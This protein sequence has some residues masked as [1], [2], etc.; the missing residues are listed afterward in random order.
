MFLGL[1]VGTGALRATPDLGPVERWLE[2]QQRVETIAASFV[3]ER[4]LKTVTKPLRTAGRMWWR[5]ASG[6]LRWQLGEPP[7]LL[8]VRPGRGEDLLV[9]KPAEK[10]GERW[11]VTGSPEGLGALA[12]LDA[13]MAGS[14]VELQTQFEITEV[15]PEATR[16]VIATKVRDR[17]LSLGV[18]R[19]EFVLDPQTSAL[20]ETNVFLR[21]GSS[22]SNQFVEVQLDAPIPPDTFTPALDGYRIS[23]KA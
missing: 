4:R 22:L 10:T 17:T 20:R 16:L 23:D 3:Q 7:K 9:L 5:K 1:A 2:K 19:F 15:V 11:K 18:R 13:G 21:D 6:S 14:L 8:V 12:L